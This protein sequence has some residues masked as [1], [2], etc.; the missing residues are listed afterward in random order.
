[1]TLHDE[2]IVLPEVAQDACLLCGSR[3]YRAAVLEAV[4]AVLGGRGDP[5]VRLRP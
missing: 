2:E 3:T 5:A 1:M 4:E